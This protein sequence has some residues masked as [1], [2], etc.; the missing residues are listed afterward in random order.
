[1]DRSRRVAVMG[2]TFDPIHYAHLLIA[3]DVRRRFRLPRVLFMPAGSP[4]HKG[5][6]EVSSAE[7]RYIMALLATSNNPHFTV[8]RLE[9]DRPGPSY[10]IATVRGLKSEAGEGAQVFF[11][12]GA[13]AVLELLTWHEPDAILDEATVVAVPRPGFD[14]DLL[15]ETLGARRASKITV[16][17]APLANISSTMIRR[18]VRAGESVRYLTPRPV[19]DYIRKR[20]LYRPADPS[21][22]PLQETTS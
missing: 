3:E 8:S 2:G 6:D 13:D 7:D 18:L 12:T 19:I 14:L 17:E 11:V 5:D 15:D 4:P 20:G 22:E 1:M 16:I 10:T 21:E 9:I